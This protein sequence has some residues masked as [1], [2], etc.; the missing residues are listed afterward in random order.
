MRRP[1]QPQGSLLTPRSERDSNPP[2]PVGTAFFEPPFERS[3]LRPSAREELDPAEKER[4]FRG[5]LQGF[6]SLQPGSEPLS[7][8]SAGEATPFGAIRSVKD[9]LNFGNRRI[10]LKTP[11]RFNRMNSHAPMERHDRS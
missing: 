8:P 9:G 3:G 5:M 2:S 10:L 7:L 11:A 6:C 1:R 4:P